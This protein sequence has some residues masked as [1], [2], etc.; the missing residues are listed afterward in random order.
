M[1]S[2]VSV[3]CYAGEHNDTTQLRFLTKCASAVPVKA[4]EEKPGGDDV[5]QSQTLPSE[6]YRQEFNTSLPQP[7]ERERDS[8][9]HVSGEN[10][11]ISAFSLSSV[12]YLE[13]C[14]GVFVFI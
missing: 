9:L 2:G 11:N 4:S 12:E 10:Q 5:I 13:K 3:L 14:L 1:S 6:Q 8:L 7:T